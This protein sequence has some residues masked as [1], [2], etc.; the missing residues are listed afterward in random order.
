MNYCFKVNLEILKISEAEEK[1][2][3]RDYM[4]CVHRRGL[5]AS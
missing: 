5:S 4:R 1:M 2:R 3:Q